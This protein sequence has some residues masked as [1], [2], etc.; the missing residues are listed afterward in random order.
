MQVS[1]QATRPYRWKGV[2]KAV[3]NTLTFWF[4]QISWRS[5]QGQGTLAQLQSDLASFTVSSS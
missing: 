2:S 1:E 4:W 5:K 3:N